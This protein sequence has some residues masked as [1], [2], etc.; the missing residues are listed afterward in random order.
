MNASDVLSWIREHRASAIGLVLVVAGC[1]MTQMLPFADPA[2]LKLFGA[3]ERAA[4][5][6]R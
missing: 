2:A 6:G 5:A 1:L 3:V 4:Y